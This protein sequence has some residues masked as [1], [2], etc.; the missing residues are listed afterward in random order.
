MVNLCLSEANARPRHFCKDNDG[1]CESAWRSSRWLGE[2]HP[3]W[4]PRVPVYCHECSAYIGEM[5]V[6]RAEAERHF[7][8][9]T[10]GSRRSE[11]YNRWMSRYYRS[12]ESPTRGEWVA[13]ECAY[14][15]TEHT[16]PRWQYD[17]ADK[18]FCPG[19]DHLGR[20]MSESGIGENSP[21]W[22][23]EARVF[24]QGREEWLSRGGGEEWRWAVYARASHHCE[25][26]GRDDQTLH[27]HHHWS[28][29][30]YPHW[31]NALWNGLCLCNDCHTSPTGLHSLAGRAERIVR[32]CSAFEA[33]RDEAMAAVPLALP[34]ATP[35]AA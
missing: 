8:K 5:A 6:G 7:C 17:G 20:W 22:L 4:V 1:A 31:R 18:H 29:T 10:D 15:G 24:S 9:A 34:P 11:C 23:G 28:W 2:D 30:L 35:R 33:N 26:C 12:E 3:N 27:A 21:R 13:F 16:M 19:T 32:A 25:C 14:C